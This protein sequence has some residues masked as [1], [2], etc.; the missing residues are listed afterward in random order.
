MPA[1]ASGVLKSGASFY[2]HLGDFRA[3]YDFDEDMA[4]PAKLQLNAPHL[5]IADYLTKAWPD[6]IDHQLHP[7][8]SLELFLGIG[9][10]ETIYPKTLGDFVRQFEIYLSTPRLRGQR[11][12]DKDR[13]RAFLLPLGNERRDGFHFSGQCQRQHFRPDAD[14]LDKNAAGGRFGGRDPSPPLWSACM[15]RCPGVRE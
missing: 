6:F 3:I 11:E 2:W 14:G 8:G 1:I 4:P 7:F 9:N 15:R 5:T 12:R 10:L 13:G